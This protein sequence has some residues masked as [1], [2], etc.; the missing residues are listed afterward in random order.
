MDRTKFSHRMMYLVVLI[1]FL[2]LLALKLHWYSLI[3]YFDMFMHF[4]GGFWLGLVSLWLFGWG[5]FSRGLALKT[6]V[7]VLIIGLGWEF[8]EILAYNQIVKES[9]DILDTVSDLLF[10]LMGGMAAL[11]WY[12]FKDVK[13]R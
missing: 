7:F 1:F 9:L 3:W 5:S 12:N 4:L 6:L 2:N 13:R 8:F 10:D 11:I